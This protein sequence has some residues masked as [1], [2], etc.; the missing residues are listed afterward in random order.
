[1]PAGP[2]VLGELLAQAVEVLHLG[3]HPLSTLLARLL[4]VRAPGDL[5]LAAWALAT[6]V[7]GSRESEPA[8]KLGFLLAMALL[9]AAAVLEA[10]FLAG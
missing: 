1:V 10:V 8:K 9:A 4:G 6:W 2:L 7:L 3:L 5:D